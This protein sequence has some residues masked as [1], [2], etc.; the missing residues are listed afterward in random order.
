M[1]TA[2]CQRDKPFSKSCPASS[3]QGLLLFEERMTLARSVTDHLSN[4]FKS[5]PTLT[6][7]TPPH[8]RPLW[9]PPT[10]SALFA[11][12][13]CSHLLK[14]LFLLS[15]PFSV[16]FLRD[17][18]LTSQCSVSALTL[19]TSPLPPPPL[20]SV[21]HAHPIPVSGSELSQPNM[22]QNFMF[23]S[24]LQEEQT[25]RD[26]WSYLPSLFFPIRLNQT[27]MIHVF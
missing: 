6:H 19:P 23:S 16:Q 2:K 4:L 9:N 11:W 14:W 15:H 1:I 27:L 18:S 12:T 8:L 21:F 17:A 22:G 10:P 7:W 24:I 26:T 25:T 13:T 3:L 20:Y 5:R